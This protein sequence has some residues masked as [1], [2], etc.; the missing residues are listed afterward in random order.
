M[1]LNCNLNADRRAHN[2][3]EVDYHTLEALWKPSWDVYVSTGTY[4]REAIVHMLW[5]D[6]TYHPSQRV[7][8]FTLFRF[9]CLCSVVQRFHFP[10]V[11]QGA[12][13]CFST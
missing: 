2:E 12:Q 8:S 6:P 9:D 11:A 7:N 10:A 4:D 3:L 1:P 13:A 5:P